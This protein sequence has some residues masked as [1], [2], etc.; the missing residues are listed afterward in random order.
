MVEEVRFLLLY[1]SQTG[2]AQAIAEQIRDEATARGLKPDLH[3]L[4]KSEK[5]V[6]GTIEPWNFSESGPSDKTLVPGTI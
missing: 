6:R 3:C 2:Q 5:E 4:D 1:G